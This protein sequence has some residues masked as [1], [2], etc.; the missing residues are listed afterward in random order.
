MKSGRSGA[1]LALILCIVLVMA[2]FGEIVF[3]LSRSAYREVDLLNG[4]LRAMGVADSAFAEIIARLSATPWSKR[5][6]RDG[7]DVQLDVPLAG[8]SYDSMIREARIKP[9][10]NDPLARTLAG[11]PHQCDLFV[12]ASYQSS[13]VAML[14]RLTI[15]EDSL[16]TY[17]RVIPVQFTFVPD[18][19]RADP[20]TM[21]RITRELKPQ[22][23][24]RDRHTP[25]TDLIVPP[26]HEATTAGEIADVFEHRPRGPVVDEVASPDD[27]T[28][29]RPN[30]PYLAG[31]KDDDGAEPE[32]P[33]DGAPPVIRAGPFAIT[34]DSSD[35]YLKP[36]NKAEFAAM[37]PEL[38]SL[39][40]KI[41]CRMQTMPRGEMSPATL[42]FVDRL[43]NRIHRLVK[44]MPGPDVDPNR[45]LS[46]WPRRA[47]QLACQSICF[48]ANATGM[49]PNAM[50]CP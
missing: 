30:G 48:G 2:A 32:P 29:V 39:L 26:L 50:R 5:W 10:I 4:H 40:E 7:A 19:S 36:R 13:T 23:E 8:G 18:T 45:R 3:L 28:N 1:T 46:Y 15:P 42:T 22:M 47:I 35:G 27:P 37:Q 33:G 20:E 25:D 41:S 31:L 14:W 12:R 38:K 6:F 49:D 11:Q 34:C 44:H 24:E 43:P 9:V 17:R 16:D 21:D